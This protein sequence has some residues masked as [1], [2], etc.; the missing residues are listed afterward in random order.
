MEFEYCQLERQYYSKLFFPYFI[1]I[2]TFL[3]KFWS[4]VQT[5]NWFLF[6]W[7]KLHSVMG[8]FECCLLCTVVWRLKGTA[9]TVWQGKWIILLDRATLKQTSSANWKSLGQSTERKVLEMALFLCWF[10]VIDTDWSWGFCWSGMQTRSA[11][12]DSFDL[13]YL[14]CNGYLSHK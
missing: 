5:Y 14:E 13:V 7:Q 4:Y 6:W 8:A 3:Q 1:Q 9:R 2:C 12:F 10:A 11:G